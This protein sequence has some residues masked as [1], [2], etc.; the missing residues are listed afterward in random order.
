MKNM[1]KIHFKRSEGEQ[2]RRY[3]VELN[4][5]RNTIILTNSRKRVQKWLDKSENA[6]EF[7]P[8]FTN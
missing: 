6:Q 5:H 4:D 1:K 3:G 2:V 7:E 8:V